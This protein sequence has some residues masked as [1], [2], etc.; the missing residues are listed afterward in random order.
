M[1]VTILAHRLIAVTY[2]QVYITY[3]ITWFEITWCRFSTRLLCIVLSRSIYVILACTSS[4]CSVNLNIL[5]LSLLNYKLQNTNLTIYKLYTWNSK[6]EIIYVC[7]LMFSPHLH[8]VNDP[9]VPVWHN[10]SS[11]TLICVTKFTISPC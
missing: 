2:L 4:Y 11:N 9:H 8:R 3:F 6:V 7:L 5:K 10:R 1:N